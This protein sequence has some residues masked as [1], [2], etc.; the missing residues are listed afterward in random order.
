MYGYLGAH[1]VPLFAPTCKT[2]LQFML[3]I[4]PECGH[5][6]LPVFRCVQGFC[7]GVGFL[8]PSDE[9]LLLEQMKLCSAS[10]E[11]G[12]SSEEKEGEGGEGDVST[13]EEQKCET[14]RFSFFP[15]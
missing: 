11:G 1:E 4:L 9:P 15:L 3:T 8:G 6:F 2:L 5:N 14:Q 7:I 10:K 12:E 13:E